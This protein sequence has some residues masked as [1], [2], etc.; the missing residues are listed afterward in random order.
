MKLS[1]RWK[2]IGLVIAI[3]I[4]GLGSLATISS[5][6]ITNKTEETV[7]EQSKSLVSQ[8]SD[9]VTNILNKYESSLLTYA[10][11]DEVI[12][13]LRENKTLFDEHDDQV[14]TDFASFLTHFSDASGIYTATTTKV[15]YEPHFDDVKNV[16]PT[17]RPWFT[18]AY[19]NP[20]TVY[21]TEPYMDSATKEFTITAAKGVKDGN[22][23]IGVIGVD[24]LLS[25]LTK[26]VSEME[27][28]YNGYPVIFDET[29]AAI[30]HPTLAG[31]NLSETSYV[32]KLLATTDTTNYTSDVENT[33]SI[34]VGTK[35]DNVN[36]SVATIYDKNEVH[37]VTKNIQVIITVITLAIMLVMFIV[38]Y[39]VISKIIRPMY[40]L[41]TLM[42]RV[43]EGDLTVQIDIN[44]K[45]EIGR[46]AHHFNEMIAQM[47]NIIGVVKNSSVKVEDR[48][49][50]LSAMAEETSAASSQVAMS[51]NE[52]A[53]SATSSS[54]QADTVTM[55]STS[56]SDKINNMSEL[57][58]GVETIT[59]EAATLNENGK[60]KMEQL[61]VSFE[62]NEAEILQ[63]SNVIR[64]LESKIT[65]IDTIMDTIS[66]VSAQTNLL[67]LNA[68]I[69]A[70]RAGE[71]GKGFAVVAEEVRKLAEQSAASTETVKT[72][73]TELQQ[74]SHAVTVRMQQMQQSFN[75]SS[76]EV[77]STNAMFNELSTMI[78]RINKSFIGVNK[79]IDS[80][81][82]YK[83][84]VLQT[85][86]ELSLNAQSTSAACE[87]VSASSDEQL[88]AIH[89]V[90]VA[91]EE[92]NQL[93]SELAVAVGRFKV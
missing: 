37:A 25:S 50:H 62:G 47:K 36:W 64:Q 43:A 10:E 60:A 29:G 93:S 82:E 72:T 67:A 28:G 78:E 76:D 23:V 80:V 7:V 48:S 56:L 40:T 13:Y 86:E 4:V 70:A 32:K 84:Q 49:Q 22:E 38:L 14:R 54:E 83:E 8:L 31:E 73:I 71:H 15:L 53:S 91:S 79:E 5:I 59:R 20:D 89:S 46:L 75:V 81:N 16:V 35:I 44:S 19:D 17:E 58:Y 85:I 61:L 90:A 63:M 21:W 3:V 65:A 52:I 33:A 6:V 51:V 41:G 12:Q 45:D 34:I 2:I 74:E 24:I 11:S 55:Q 9:N 77:E 92:L 42:G 88:Q 26:M 18:N 66:S 1:I 27:I 39:V 87:E 68:S 30:V 69:E 57:S